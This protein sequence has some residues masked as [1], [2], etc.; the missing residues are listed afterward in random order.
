MPGGAGVHAQVVTRE[1]KVFDDF[2]ILE[3]ENAIHVLNAPSPA[4]TASF[5]IG[6]HIAN[7]I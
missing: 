5:S 6:K 3:E 1:G 7:L 4:A 2:S